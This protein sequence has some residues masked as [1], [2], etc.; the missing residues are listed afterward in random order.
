[1]RI[2]LV[3]S[4]IICVCGV[5]SLTISGWGIADEIPAPRPLPDYRSQLAHGVISELSEKGITIRD[6]DG[7]FVTFAPS[8]ELAKGEHRKVGAASYSYRW[9]DVRVGDKVCLCTSRIQGRY[10]CEG[11]CIVRRPGG[12]VPPA[13]GERADMITRRWHELMNAEQAEEEGREPPPRKRT[14]SSGSEPS[15]DWKY[16]LPNGMFKPPLAPMPREVTRP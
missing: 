8:A 5:S 3:S 6:E 12:L 16:Y 11:I 14:T 10:I 13:P 1:M 4:L 2:I 15:I 9:N 7:K